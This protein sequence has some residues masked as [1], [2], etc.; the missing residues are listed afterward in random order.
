MRGDVSLETLAELYSSGPAVLYVN[1]AASPHESLVPAFISASFTSQF[2]WE[3]AEVLG[4]ADFWDSRIH[5]DDRDRVTSFMSD[6][7][8]D[9]RAVIE[10]RFLHKD[11][12]YRSVCDSVCLVAGNGQEGRRAIG[13]ILDITTRKE[14]QK[15]LRLSEERY[16]MLVEHLNEGI[17]VRDADGKIVYA[18]ESFCRLLG[19]GREEI[20]GTSADDIAVDRSKA[21]MRRELQRRKQG[22]EEPYETA[23]RRKDG[24]IVH[25]IHSPRAMF[26]ENGQFVGSFAVVTDITHRKQAEEALQEAREAEQVEMEARKRAEAELKK[27]SEWLNQ[28][29]DNMMDGLVVIDGTG[30]I[31]SFN[32]AAAHMF[33]YD[34]A[35]VLNRDVGILMSS[36][37]AAQ[38]SAAVHRYLETGKRHALGS[39]PRRLMGRRRDGST[40]P[41]DIAISEM[42][43]EDSYAFIG[44]IRDATAQRLAEEALIRAKQT[45]EAANRTKSD[46]LANVSHELRTPLNAVLG[47]AEIMKDHS[48]EN[49]L[50][51]AYRDY[52]NHI[53]R[54]GRHLLDL[55]NDLLDLSKVESG[56]D[57]LDE[58]PLDIDL[59]IDGVIRLL[60]DQAKRQNIAIDVRIANDMPA[61]QADRRKLV[62]VLFNLLGNAI[63]FSRP[64]GRIWICAGRNSDG[65]VFLSVIDTGIGMA[66][67]RIALALEPFRQ[68][69]HDSTRDALGTGLGLPLAKALTERHGGSLE[70]T[71]ELGVGTSIRLNL[72]ADRV[73]TEQA[74][75]SNVEPISLWQATAS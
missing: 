58:E 57:E 26:D 63:K 37:D 32:P 5:P 45:A 66:P 2:G 15:A 11:G 54:S 19:Y 3:S 36:N 17:G 47:F 33:G 23:L 69:R 22:V 53:Y 39:G 60:R 43:G 31:R 16:Q 72:P 29:M 10:Y 73:L 75:E 34:S 24:N 42:R 1:E 61:I 56:V 7:P 12:S 46:F 18:N 28:I 35:E 51:P 71:S 6:L 13:Y 65:G 50:S 9:R 55:I 49:Q 8:Q 48:G 52:V 62:Q 14:A 70:I 74:E 68:A 4:S 20:I 59:L 67:D 38:H 44:V 27:R 21:H 41:I 30:R 64:G 40:F 25:A